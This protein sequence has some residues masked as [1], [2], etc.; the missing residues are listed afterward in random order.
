MLIE[1]TN[2]VASNL[3]MG[4]SAA[5]IAGALLTFI[6]DITGIKLSDRFLATLSVAGSL[7]AIAA[8]VLCFNTESYF[9]IT[10]YITFGLA[11][12]SC[13][14]DA[15]SSVMVSLFGMVSIAAAFASP[16][17]A[18]TLKNQAA[19]NHYWKLFFI[20]LFGLLQVILSD[21]AI[22]FLVFWEVM[23]IAASTLI[24]SDHIRHRA[25]R[26]SIAYITASRTSTAFLTAAFLWMHS[27]SSSWQFS[28]WHFNTPEALV[29]SA[30]IL[31]GTCTKA[32]I[33]PMH[34]YLP[35]SYSEPPGPVAALI[36]GL[37]GKMG[38]YVMLRLLIEGD[39]N[40]LIIA[41][42][43][44]ALGTISCV[45]G[46]IF[47]LVERDLK[48][49]LAYSSVENMGLIM[50]GMAAAMLA[51]INGFTAVGALAITGVLFHVVN[52][53]LFKALLM[54]GASHI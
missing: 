48:R 51:K 31:L 6:S 40:S 28:Q 24:A 47:A 52:H 17:F 29:A 30:L 50:V 2:P 13:H 49:L 33:W 37:M 11:P 9:S 8:V 7:L 38:I 25:Q 26:A 3:Y 41:Y 27:L 4:A 18:S 23:S 32:G 44:L 16:S 12:F 19:K 46:I 21:N 20:F 43:A 39:C 22:A 54:L 14:S 53:G 34:V 5:W 10:K 1:T 42:V 35:Q 36:C 45:W 15:L